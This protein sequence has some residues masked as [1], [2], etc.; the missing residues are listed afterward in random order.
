MSGTAARLLGVAYMMELPSSYSST[1]PPWL[2][3]ME[4]AVDGVRASK[5][6]EKYVDYLEMV[7]HWIA[8]AAEEYM[9]SL[10]DRS[11]DISSR[12]VLLLTC[13]YEVIN[14]TGDNSAL[15]AARHAVRRIRG[16]QLQK[17]ST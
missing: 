9:E 5:L 8:P 12:L 14:Y 15:K 10:E 1:N 6:D 3:N 2:G 11:P 7:E 13:F 4:A 16:G 17:E